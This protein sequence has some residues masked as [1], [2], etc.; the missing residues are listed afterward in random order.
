MFSTRQKSATDSG[1]LSSIGFADFLIGLAWEDTVTT[2]GCA[3][4]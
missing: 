1:R 2:P 3:P 4:G